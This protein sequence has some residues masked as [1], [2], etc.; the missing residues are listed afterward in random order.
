M[1]LRYFVKDRR[2]AACL[3][4]FEASIKLGYKSS[5]F[6]SNIELGKRQPPIILLRK[7]CETYNVDLSEMKNVY[8]YD[9][10]ERARIAA[11]ERWDMAKE[12]P[13]LQKF[14]L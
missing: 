13:R 5:Q 1:L 10:R 14:F 7:M 9:T 2:I 4:Q 3:T 12:N 6:L 11:T 8:I